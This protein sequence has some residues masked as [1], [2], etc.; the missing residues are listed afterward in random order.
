MH[1]GLSKL[2]AVALGV[3]SIGD[4]VQWG[5]VHWGWSIHWGVRIGVNQTGGG[6]LWVV[7]IEV[8]YIGLML[9]FGQCKQWGD[10]G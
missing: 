8:V 2:E 1:W 10:F 6:V 5:C 7:H 3:V 9:M 4:G